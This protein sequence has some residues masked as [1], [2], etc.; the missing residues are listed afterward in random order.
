MPPA[1]RI[2][3]HIGQVPRG[4][5]QRDAPSGFGF[6]FG[7]ANAG[8]N[9]TDTVASYVAENASGVVACVNAIA[10]GLASLPIRTYRRLPGGGRVELTDAD[11]WLPRLLRRPSPQNTWPELCE[12]ML[13]SALLHGN[14]VALITYDPD[15]QPTEL[16]P[17]P[18]MC[19]TP[20][21]TANYQL[22]FDISLTFGPF[23]GPG[24]FRRYL[25]TETLFL[26][27]RSDNGGWTGRSRLSRSP[28]VLTAAL[29]VGAY[30]ASVYANFAN[31]SGVLSH[32]GRLNSDAR[33]FLASEFERSHAGPANA[34]RLLVLDESM[35]W[36]ASAVSPVDAETMEARK[37]SI[38]ELCRL[39]GVPPSV[40]FSNENNAFTSAEQQNRQFASGCLVPWARRLE[41]A[42][43]KALLGD[44]PDIHVEID[45]TSL[46]RGDYAARWASYATA[47]QNGILSVAEVRDQEGYGPVPMPAELV[48]GGEL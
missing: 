6:G 37:F 19:A 9:Q 36:T 38:P 46:V 31:P 43:E 22:S 35:T 27:D 1:A 7:Y 45:F 5:E 12:F 23:A 20:V 25:S 48:P 11:H 14:A 33:S 8:L 2:E 41:Q 17:V 39:F 40:V 29:A 18:W 16:Y 4:V 34:R 28:A 3:P 44:E 47:L 21:L 10:S 15:G 42:I 13:A 32:P 30:S 26:K 24:I